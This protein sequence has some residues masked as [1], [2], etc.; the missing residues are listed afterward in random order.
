MGVNIDGIAIGK[1][2]DDA[3]AE[4]DAAQTEVDRL[5]LLIAI[6]RAQV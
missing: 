6:N 4:V 5:N 1:A 2:I 3:N